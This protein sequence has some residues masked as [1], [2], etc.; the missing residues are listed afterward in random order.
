MKFSSIPIL[1]VTHNRLPYT[2]HALSCLLGKYAGVPTKITIF[3]NN[4]TDGTKV[5]LK[6]LYPSIVSVVLLDVLVS[7]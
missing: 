2:V 1:M 5:W 4:S 6:N 3:D 7:F